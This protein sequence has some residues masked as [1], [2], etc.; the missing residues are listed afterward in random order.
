MKNTAQKL[1]A[2]LALCSGILFAQETERAVVTVAVLKMR[3]EPA[4]T[5]P[6]VTVIK[7]G[8]I[9]KILAKTDAEVTIDNITD[10]WYRVESDGKTGWLFGGYTDTGFKAVGEN[11]NLLLWQARTGG[12]NR[13][14]VAFDV[15]AQKERRFAAL[16]EVV[17]CEFSEDLKYLACDSGT[18]K[19]GSL[20]V[21]D[22]Q[23]A[24]KIFE[25]PYEPREPT[26]KANTLRFDQVLCVDDGFTI[27]EEK[28]IAAGQIKKTGK[29]RR[30]NFHVG[31]TS[32]D[33]AMYKKLV[34]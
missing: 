13:N 31:V 15:V 2:C 7:K 30:G 9:V 3:S 16:P 24:R 4:A 19:I 5:A 34:K 29:Y 27:K 22:F 17:G 33:C 28:V 25:G 1:F 12:E 11:S 18:D 8:T 14:L 21:F 10:Y 23:T 6:V 20:A 26:W 32:G